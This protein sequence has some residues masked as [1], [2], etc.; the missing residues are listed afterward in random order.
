MWGTF[1]SEPLRIVGLVGRYPANCLMRRMPIP[2]RN[3][4]LRPGGDA[5]SGR[6]RVLVRFSPGY[7]RPRA[8]LHTCYSPVRRS[9]AEAG[10]PASPLPLD[11]HVL[12]LSLAFILSQDQTLRCC[13][14]SFLLFRNVLKKA[15]GEASAPRPPD[16]GLSLFPVSYSSE[17]PE[18]R[19]TPPRRGASRTLAPVLLSNLSI[20]ILSMFSP[21]CRRNSFFRKRRKTLQSY[22][23]F[24]EPPNFFGVFF[25]NFF[26]GASGGR[27]R[28]NGSPAEPGALP[29]GPGRPPPPFLPESDREV[30]RFF[31]TSKIFPWKIPDFN[32]ISRIQPPNRPKW[33]PKAPGRPPE[34]GEEG[35]T[36]GEMRGGRSRGN[37]GGRSLH[38]TGTLSPDEN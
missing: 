12:S 5:P 18:A 28:G 34:G 19:P 22:G 13:M 37:R 7:P 14:L 36:A 30:T 26:F 35:E 10:K 25:R 16:D 4:F 27:S 3:R 38:R 24:P 23:L 9:P 11:L 2:R 21:G 6:R 33:P 15:L 17:S 8:R 31:R 1:L 32:I 20:A 29:G